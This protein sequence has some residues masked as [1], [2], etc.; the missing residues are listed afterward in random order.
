M[1]ID[2]AGRRGDVGAVV[3][4]GSAAIGYEDIKEYTHDPLDRAS[5]CGCCSRRSRSSRAARAPR[6]RSPTGSRTRALRT[7]SIAANKLEKQWGEL[8]DR[9]GGARSRLWYLPHGGPHRRARQYPAAYEQR[10]TAFL[11][12]HLLT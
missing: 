7:C 11:D 3:A 8:Y 6:S 2:A 5:R 1:A 10:V 9:R 12:A 4:D